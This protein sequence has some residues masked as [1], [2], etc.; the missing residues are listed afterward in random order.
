VETTLQPFY[1]EVI[2]DDALDKPLDYQVPPAFSTKIKKGSRVLVTVRNRATKGIVIN[3]KN[4]SEWTN[5]KPIRDLLT[6]D[7]IIPEDLLK[8]GFWISEYYHTPFQRV[9]KMLLPSSLRKDMKAKEQLYVMRAQTREAL[10]LHCEKIRAK[11]PK[12]AEVLDAMLKATKGILLTEL[13]EQTKGSR[14][15]VDTLVKQGFLCVDIVRID[16]SP[17]V[18]EEYFRTKPKALNEE[19]AAALEKIKSTLTP[20]SFATHLLFGITGSG[21]TEVYLQAIDIAL[22]QNKG[23]IMLV[24]EISLTTQTIERFRSRFEG[25]IAI[26]HHRL[27]HGERTDE[28]KR[29]ASGEAKI[30]IGARSAIFSPI[31]NVG[32]IIVD[33][34][35][36][37]SYKNS[38]EMPTYHARD[39]AVVRGKFSS[40][41]VILGSA[42]PSLESYYNALSGKYLL[43][44]LKSRPESAKIPTVSIVD[45]RIE[46]EKN[47]G[48]T[49][50]SAPLLDGIKARMEKG[51][52]T[53]L[54]LNRRGYHTSLQCLSCQTPVKC[55][56]CDVALTFHL[57]DNKLAC[58]LC[59]FHLQPPPAHCPSCESPTPMKFKGS[60][61]EQVER[62]LHAV[63]PNIRTIRVDADSTKHKG[64]QQKLLRDF[65][66]GKADV[67]IGTQMIAKGLHFSEVTLVGVLN[68]DAAINIPDFRSGETAFQLMTQ[69]AGRAGRGVTPGEVIIQTTMP[70]N[71]AIQF[72]SKQDFEGFYGYEKESRETFEYP[73]FTQMVKIH[74]SGEHEKHVLELSNRYRSEIIKLLPGNYSVNP[75][76]PAGH[77]KVKDQYKFQ[78]FVRGGSISV[79]HKAVKSVSTQ[80]PKGIRVLIDVNC[81]STF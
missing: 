62:A 52:Q 38:E 70:D 4:S 64:S 49:H 23:V 10:R 33:E 41:T 68:S 74:F 8:L 44:V 67:L 46:F 53:I 36:E 2:L 31:Q 65:G 12:Q 59:G 35:H 18:K 19:Q 27:S 63:F 47:K 29:M 1:A 75:T 11:S 15:P 30:A 76:T 78:F 28:W 79:I 6:E 72:A 5:V 55:K 40:A 25:K 9:L 61:T 24:P 66:N 13:L 80:I 32:L 51:E 22:Q 16:R 60:G 21:K 50:F 57:G 48:F 20:H 39:V 77:G 69:V 58:H 43:S 56:H 42:T 14:S 3:L 54:F 17:L 45:M 81:L 73:P 37:G 26:L 71:P 34:E 7:A